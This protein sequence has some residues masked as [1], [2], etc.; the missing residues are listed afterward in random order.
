MLRPHLH[1][2]L[3]FL[4]V[5]QRCSQQP[6]AVCGE[7]GSLS[8]HARTR[9]SSYVR[10]SLVSDGSASSIAAY[11][12]QEPAA[13]LFIG[14]CLWD[15]CIIIK[16]LVVC[17]TG[18]YTFRALPLS[19]M[20]HAAC[21]DARSSSTEQRPVMSRQMQTA[22]CIGTTRATFGDPGEMVHSA[23]AVSSGVARTPQSQHT[24]FTFRPVLLLSRS[25]VDRG[26]D[27]SC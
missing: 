26:A 3:A 15:E 27:A 1:P 19:H 14:C 5:I 21:T 18:W 22:Y 7:R 4:Q 16:E 6:A 8:E 11:K 10:R 9:C 24:G 17:C 13:R 23:A 2:Q 12:A 25:V 20:A